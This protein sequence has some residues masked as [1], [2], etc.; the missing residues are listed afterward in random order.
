MPSAIGRSKRPES[1][2]RSAGARLTVMRCACG[3]AKPHCN[4]AARTRSRASLT[5][6]SASPTSVK[7][8]SPGA[9]CTSTCTDGAARPSSE[10]LRTRARDIGRS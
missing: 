4:S 1:L 9:S 10:R 6:V 2:G 8:G 7:L 3:N 5:S